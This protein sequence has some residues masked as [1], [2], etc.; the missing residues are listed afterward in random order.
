MVGESPVLA[1]A[2]VVGTPVLLRYVPA[3]RSMSRPH[4]RRKIRCPAEAVL[5]LVMTVMTLYHLW[6]LSPLSTAH[7]QARDIFRLTGLPIAAPS[8]SLR[9]RASTLTPHDLGLQNFAATVGDEDSNDGDAIERL[10]H[11]LSSMAGRV[12]IEMRLACLRGEKG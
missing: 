4:L 1:L 10:L 7:R 11:R 9:A 8:A 12:S 5:L 2:L 6:A 3:L